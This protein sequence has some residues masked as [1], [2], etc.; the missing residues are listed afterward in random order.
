MLKIRSLKKIY[1]EK[2]VNE[3]VALNNINLYLDK[4]EFVTIIGSN[5]SGK[6]TLLNCISGVEEPDEGKIIL[7]TQ[8][9]THLPEHNRAKYIGRVFQDPLKGTAFNM[10]VEENL[11]LALA[12]GRGRGIGRGIKKSE[13]E[14]FREKLSLLNLGLENQMKIKMGLLS[15]GQ[16]QA[17]T[18]IMATI[19]KPKLL[20]LD[21][22]VSALDPSTARTVMD[23]TVKLI[24]KEQ[25]CTLM[26]THNLNDALEF[27]TRTILLS[28]GI[29]TLDLKGKEK[30]LTKVNDLMRKFG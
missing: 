1:S 4:G 25:I 9:I 27:G 30:K 23:I 8:D 24:K 21:E 22:H 15:G 5:G 19:V 2:D 13:L 14:L 10:T 26:V 16:R 20:L 28:C 18:L 12:R 6:S 11:S 29:I 17:I 3:K 7:D